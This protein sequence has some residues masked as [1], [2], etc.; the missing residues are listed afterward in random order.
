VSFCLKNAPKVFSGLEIERQIKL[1]L[2]VAQ[3]QFKIIQKDQIILNS[4][5]VI[6]CIKTEKREKLNKG[7]R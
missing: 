2:Q 1:Y 6:L 4:E 5:I 7:I 3:S